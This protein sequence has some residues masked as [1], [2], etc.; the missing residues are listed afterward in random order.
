MLLM[1][2]G[3]LKATEDLL[4]GLTEGVLMEGLYLGMDVPVAFQDLFAFS[5]E[6]DDGAFA[7][8]AACKVMLAQVASPADI[9]NNPIEGAEISLLTSAD[10]SLDM[11]ELDAGEYVLTSAEGLEYQPGKSA[12]VVGN[13]GDLDISAAVTMPDPPLDLAMESVIAVD[14]PT[15]VSMLDAGYENMIIAVY[16][17]TSGKVTWD[18]VP[19]D[20]QGLYDFTRP[21]APVQ[22][23]EIP[24]EAFPVVG[25]YI[26]GVAGMEIADVSGF[27][28]VNTTLSAFMAGQ[29]TLVYVTVE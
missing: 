7:Y 18:N 13:L 1:G 8:T 23:V 16:N 12:T 6:E 28:G 2:C 11:A 3:R 5:G 20:F 29:M 17:L 9:G 22:L 19:D 24:G 27:E 26:I 21:D 25:S 14:S 4:D 10:G 15:T